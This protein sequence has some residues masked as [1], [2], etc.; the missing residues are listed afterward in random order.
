MFAT[1]DMSDFK[2]WSKLSMEITMKFHELKI[3]TYPR[4]RVDS[5]TGSPW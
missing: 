5:S 2:N 1:A 3:S 4:I